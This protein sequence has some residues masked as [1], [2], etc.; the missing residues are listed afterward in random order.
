VEGYHHALLSTKY[1]ASPR[2]VMEDRVR[3][4]SGTHTAT[5]SM[6]MEEFLL[7]VMEQVR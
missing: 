2:H 4:E 1:R 6:L 7:G 5:Y 3:T